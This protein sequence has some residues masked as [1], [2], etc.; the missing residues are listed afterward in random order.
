M[1]INTD[2]IIIHFPTSEGVS[3]VSERSGRRKQSKQSGAGKRVCPA[4]ERANGR[5][6]GP[7]LQ[8]VFLAVLD[9]SAVVLTM[10]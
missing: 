3:K 6:S 7:L 8:Y 5:A 1:E 2:K 4:S 10:H 9:H